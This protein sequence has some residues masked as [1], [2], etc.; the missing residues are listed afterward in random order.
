[1]DLGKDFYSVR[2]SLKEDMDAMLKNG[3][4]FF[5]GHFLSIRPWELFFK[6]A[7][8]SVSSIAV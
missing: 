5:G 8:A 3:S 7:S 1:M 2:F 6:P 4:W